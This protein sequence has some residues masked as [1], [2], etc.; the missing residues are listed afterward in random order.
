MSRKRSRIR[1]T[2]DDFMHSLVILG[3]MFRVET[4]LLSMPRPKAHCEMKGADLGSRK[5]SQSIGF[6]NRDT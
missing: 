1:S 2:A 5:E 3:I 4:P 6:L